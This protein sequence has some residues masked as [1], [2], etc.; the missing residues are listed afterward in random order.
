MSAWLL[1]GLLAAAVG[2]VVFQ[3]W[4]GRRRERAVFRCVITKTMEGEPL[5]FLVRPTRKG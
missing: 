1:A 4:K 3:E 5:Q 2:S